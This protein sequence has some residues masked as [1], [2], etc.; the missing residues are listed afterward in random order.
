MADKRHIQRL[1]RGEK[2]WNDWRRECPEI[3]PD[4]SGATLRKIKFNSVNLSNANLRGANLEGAVL[5]G[6]IL[7]GANLRDANLSNA[8]IHGTDLRQARLNGVNLSGA[9]FRNSYLNNATL[10]YAVM[11]ETAFH[12]IELQ[13]VEGLEDVTHRGPS[14][15][16]LSTIILSEGKIPHEFL[17][18][19]G[20]PDELITQIPALVASIQPIQFHSCFISYSTKD[21]EFARRLHERMRTARLRVWFAPE[22]IKGGEKL[23]EQIDRAIQVHDRLLIILSEHSLQSE[24]VMTEIRKARKTEVEEQRRKLFPI[25]LVDY[26]ALRHWEC[27]DADHGKDLAVEVREYFIPD[28]TN[29]KSHDEFERAFTRLLADLKASV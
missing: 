7:K 18:G 16:A 14:E 25:R 11:S 26:K 4:F 5:R 2:V 23:H 27:F 20:V 9:L 13:E 28:F 29:W 3:V 21:E 17:R 8:I 1:R 10:K 24:W 12:S 6:G 15:I 19:C 22:D